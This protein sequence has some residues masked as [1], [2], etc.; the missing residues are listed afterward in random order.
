MWEWRDV[1]LLLLYCKSSFL[2]MPMRHWQLFKSILWVLFFHDCEK[3]PDLLVAKI[4]SVQMTQIRGKGS[5]RYPFIRKR[6]ANRM[7]LAVP[8]IEVVVLCYLLFSLGLESWKLFAILILYQA[9]LVFH[10]R[11]V[12][13]CI[14]ISCFVLWISWF[15]EIMKLFRCS[16]VGQK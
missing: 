2:E 5:R 10:L 8:R 11:K 7:P 15:H 3:I 13:L 14:T 9:I 12:F 6:M 4:W 16:K 1:A